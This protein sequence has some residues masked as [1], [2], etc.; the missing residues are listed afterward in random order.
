MRPLLTLF[1][2]LYTLAVVSCILLALGMIVCAVLG[3]RIGRRRHLADPDAKDLATGTVDAA[4]LSLLG[5]LIAFTFSSAYGRFEERRRLIVEEANA[6]GTAYLRLEL[7][8]ATAQGPLR[9][10][11]REYVHSRYEFWQLAPVRAAALAEYDR[12]TNLQQEIWSAAV[13]ATQGESYG[14]ARM[15][16][17]PAL[18]QMIDVTTT[19]LII[20]QAHPPLLI[21]V[22]LS[23]LALASAAVSGFAMAKTAN[24]SYPHLI[25]LA[26]VAALAMY[27]IL[28]IEFPRFGLVTLDVPHELL[29]DMEDQMK[30]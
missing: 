9:A 8:P 27:M 12:S 7:L 14:Q 19:R 17:L 6:I 3:H 23:A 1:M 28:D 2:N 22:L 15:L 13:D 4:V 10:K 24:P 18:N 5:L 20:M 16:L 29:R 25:G 21:Y 11:F 26:L 30:S